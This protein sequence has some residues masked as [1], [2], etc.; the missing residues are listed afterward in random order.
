MPR[1]LITVLLFA[2][3]GLVVWAMA[4][5]INNSAVDQDPKAQATTSAV[6]EAAGEDS[7]APP[8]APGQPAATTTPVKP[9]EGLHVLPAANGAVVPLLGH[10]ESSP[11]NPYTMGVKLT[12]WG[13]GINELQLSRYSTDVAKPEDRRPYPLQTKATRGDQSVYPMAARSVVVN[14]VEVALETSRWQVISSDD[15]SVTLG[16]TLADAQGQP[17]LKVTRRWIVE[18]AAEPKGPARHTLGLEQKL[19]NVGSE[20]LEVVF[21]QYGPVDL[22]DES[23]YVGDY[24]H[25]LMGY[26]Q[27]R[28][29]SETSYITTTDFDLPRAGVLESES[30]G[31]WPGVEAE[32]GRDLLWAAMSNRYFATAV[33]ATPADSKGTS[34]QR[35]FPTITRVA[36]GGGKPETRSLALRL[37]TGVLRV[38]AG[39]AIALNLA[40][41]AGPKAPELLNADAEYKALGLGHAIVYNLGGC[42]AP[43]TFSWLANGLFSFMGFI[44]D[45]L[46]DWGMA[47][48]V[49]VAVVR[50]ILHPLTKSSQVNMMKLSRQMQEIQP[51]MEKLKTKYKDNQT[52]LN[53]EM[54]QLYRE[55]GVNPASMGLG[56]LPMFLQMPIWFALYAM[57]YFAIELRHQPAFWGVFQ[58]I[59]GGSW[60]FLSDLSSQDHFI[61]FPQVDFGWFTIESINILPLLMGVV[62]FLQQKYMT[63]PSPN[64][65]AE[66][67]Q[68]Q[69]IMKWMTTL[70]MPLF[71]Y[72]AP[73]GLTLYILTST[74][75]GIW[76]SRRVRAHVKELEASG[77]LNEKKAPPK[78]GSFMDRIHKAMD[79]RRKLIEEQMKQQKRNNK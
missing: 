18:Q 60:Q 30:D 12:A 38:E 9:I 32:P 36:W 68:Q 75:V 44:H 29:Q 47:I 21:S 48:I 49:L 76:E 4:R 45:L 56:C 1:W 51:E 42:C 24:R 39:G 64:M 37:D 73:S 3:A 77:K 35:L 17:V 8:V 67:K 16:V 2:G 13:A 71:L 25:V 28:R 20:A 5:N 69:A 53:S 62:F 19:E 57:L 54:M 46:M 31:I 15:V 79:A 22:R 11:Q 59:S 6:A 63:P 74:A 66:M 7:S 14:G 72:K 40:L 78:P 52:K 70:M 10:T 61:T 33:Y 23:S 50:L 41:Y 43:C 65:S 26:R 27:Q 58:Q 34:L 55:K